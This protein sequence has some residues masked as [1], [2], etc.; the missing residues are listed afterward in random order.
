M[1]VRL[2]M[3]KNKKWVTLSVKIEKE[4]ADKLDERVKRD[5]LEMGST[6][7]RSCI[8]RKALKR[9]LEY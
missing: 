7:N 3:D 4:I 5:A 8:V 6:Y 1:S 9:Y 2:P